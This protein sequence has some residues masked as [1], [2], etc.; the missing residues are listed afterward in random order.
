M[1]ASLHHQRFNMRFLRLT[2]LALALAAGL[3]V[4][5]ADLADAARLGGGRSL[6]SRGSKT[7]NAPPSTNTAPGAAPIDRSITPRTAP[8]TAQNPA[9]GVN[10][11]TR[12]SMFGGWRGLLMGGLFVAALGGI[13]GF[14]ALA[15]MLG[16]LLQFALIAG[17][18][19]LAFAFFRR[20]SQPSMA[21]ASSGYGRRPDPAVFQREAA[22]AMG[23]SSELKIGQADLDSFER[24]L[25]EIQTAY[26]RE[27][28]EELGSKTTPEMLSY[29]LEEISDLQKQ[30]V[31]NE[32]SDVKLL[33]G[34][35]AEAWRENGSDYATV[36]IRYAL[37][38]VTV[39]R[40]TGRVVAG[41]ASQPG[42]VTE[43]WTFRRD[44]RARADGWQLSAIQQAA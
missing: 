35:L 36:A 29:F 26:S 11:A 39:D 24:L 42:E 38:D 4:V 13:F 12:P 40:K 28:T 15:S 20:R 43:L 34:D 19:Y 1:F 27:D 30:G 37:T 17:L 7:F 5:S 41:D 22:G 33:Q 16:F 10:A 14:G 23:G 9:A 21:A 25:G 32:I 2:G 44:D 18:I 8:T 31:R 6:G 3:A